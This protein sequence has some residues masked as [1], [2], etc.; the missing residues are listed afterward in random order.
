[1]LSVIESCGC[2]S[3]GTTLDDWIYHAKK[4]ILHYELFSY[5]NPYMVA[6]ISTN[7]RRERWNY[8]NQSYRI[9][10]LAITTTIITLLLFIYLRKTSLVVLAY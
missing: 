1:M 6:C 9:L 8:G 2:G 3:L 4:E 10:T 7:A 5:S